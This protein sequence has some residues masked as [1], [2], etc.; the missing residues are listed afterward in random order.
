MGSKVVGFRCTADRAIAPTKLVGTHLCLRSK[1]PL[2]SPRQRRCGAAAGGV[3]RASA[4]AS[5]DEGYTTDGPPPGCA[6]YS[7]E[8]SK[9]LG[10]VL[11]ERKNAGTIVVAELVR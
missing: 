10:I 9:P 6:R 2:W 7:V 1:T 8:L 5:D 3:V 11:E 4:S